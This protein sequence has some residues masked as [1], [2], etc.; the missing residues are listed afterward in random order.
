MSA[1]IAINSPTNIEVGRSLLGEFLIRENEQAERPEN[2]PVGCTAAGAAVVGDVG[3]GCSL[4]R[5]LIDLKLG[6]Y[7]QLERRK[8]KKK[9]V[10]NS[11]S[12]CESPVFVWFCAQ[13][14]VIELPELLR[15][16]LA[17]MS[18]QDTGGCC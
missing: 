15:Q 16:H 2:A 10:S 9:N 17:G 13:N 11:N 1:Q 6:Y 7:V 3:L 4:Y 12:N 18:T 8:K 5:L 14:T